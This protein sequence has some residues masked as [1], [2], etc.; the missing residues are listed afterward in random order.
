[1]CG[2]LS[3]CYVG[4]YLGFALELRNMFGLLLV[5]FIQVRYKVIDQEKPVGP[6]ASFGQICFN[7]R[8]KPNLATL[9]KFGQTF[10]HLELTLKKILTWAESQF[11]RDLKQI[12]RLLRH[13]T[14]GQTFTYIQCMCAE[15]H[16]WKVTTHQYKHKLPKSSYSAFITT[17]HN[18]AWRRLNINVNTGYWEYCYSLRRG[19]KNFFTHSGGVPWRLNS[20]KCICTLSL[21]SALEF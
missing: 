7:L 13:V 15:I 1:M 19:L 4:G 3:G 2:F 12:D 20:S 14:F 21:G 18:C 8:K 5:L 11:D 17:R 16:T 10:G 9:L 6:V